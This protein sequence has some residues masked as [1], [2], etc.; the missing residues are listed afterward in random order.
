MRKNFLGILIFLLLFETA[1]C[2]GSSKMTD[3]EG[4]TTPYGRPLAHIHTTRVAFHLF[5][6]FPLFGNASVHRATHDF[7]MQAKSL[8]ATK[9]NI[10][11]TER[12]NYWF[13]F[14]PFTFLL[15]PVISSVSGDALA[16]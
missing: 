8:G 1:G 11:H 16:D 2:A 14:P 6:R 12:V 3:Y 4:M 9:I 7:M 13:G 15:T 10:D 5:T